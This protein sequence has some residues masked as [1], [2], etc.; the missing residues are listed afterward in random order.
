MHADIYAETRRYFYITR[1]NYMK[2]LQH[3]EI[4]DLDDAFRQLQRALD[5]RDTQ[6]SYTKQILEA[7]QSRLL[8]IFAAVPDGVIVL[9]QGLRISIMNAAGEKFCG[10]PADSV[11][12]QHFYSLFPKMYGEHQNVLVPEEERPAAL[13]IRLRRNASMRGFIERKDSKRFA[14]QFTAMPMMKDDA[15]VGVVV[16]MHDITEELGAEE[17]LREFVSIAS[18]QLRSPLA[19]ILWFLELLIEGNVGEISKPQWE[20]LYQSYQAA[21]RMKNIINLLLSVS[22]IETGRLEV[23]PIIGDL[24]QAIEETTAT[25]LLF[26]ERKKQKL[27]SLVPKGGDL[28]IAFDKALFVIVLEN[29]LSNAIKYTPEGGTIELSARRTD[30][31][32]VVSVKDNGLGIPQEAKAKIFTK[33]FRAENV[34]MTVPDGSGLGIYIAKQVT[35][36]W[37]G[38][39]WFQSEEGQGTTF[40][41]TI[42]VSGML[43]KKGGRSIEPIAP[44][45]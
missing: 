8:A 35:E 11:L 30:D 26:A 23:R 19:S 27:I 22:R 1:I 2:F 7:S 14:V 20:Y 13:A 28:R 9:D 41:F 45:F 15:L 24:V 39:I 44:M 38:R 43:P 31:S 12:W 42:P 5:Q 34:L 6:L 25:M 16:S 36:L 18:H 3:N 17:S 32:M 40:S 33:F 4:S 21:E 10:A 29:L 37:G